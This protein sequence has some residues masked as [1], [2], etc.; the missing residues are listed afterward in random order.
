MKKQFYEK[1]LPTQG[2]Y[3]ATGIK[4]GKAVNRFAETL[5][6]LMA[7]TDEFAARGYH[8]FVA[9]NSFSGYSRKGDSAQYARSFFI[10]L[11]VGNDP[12][13]YASKDDAAV[14]L[15]E[16][17]EREGMP[18]PVVID[19]GTGL[20]AYW[21]LDQDVPTAEWRV[22][23]ERFKQYCLAHLKID[24]V[25]TADP[26]RIM[27]CPETL[28]YKTTPPSPVKFLTDNFSQC[29][30]ASFK[31]VLGDDDT[32]RNPTIKEVLSHA[33]L[34]LDEDT[35]KVS[36]ADANIETTFE[37]IA[38]KSLE[39]RGCNQIKYVLEHAATLSEPLWHSGLSI[40]RQCV[41]WGSAI[42][43]MSEDYPRYDRE[44]TI[45]KANDTY[46][47]PHG[48]E[49][50]ELRNPGGCDGCPHKGKITNPLYFG[51]NVREPDP[52]ENTV[53]VIEDTKTVLSFSQFPDDM[54]P[55]RRGPEGGIYYITEKDQPVEIW[56]YDLYPVKRMYGTPEGEFMLMRHCPP[57]DPPREFLVSMS[58]STGED[59]RKLLLSHGVFFANKHMA[60]M[61]DYIRHWAVH[62]QSKDSAEETRRQ[63]GWT[64]DGKGFVVGETEYRSDGTTKRT[65]PSAFVIQVSRPM[66]PRGSY[67]KWKE[68]ANKLNMPGLETFA[69]PM[70][71]AF[72]SPLLRF[73]N[74]S[75]VT[76]SYFG[77][78]GIGKTGALVAAASLFGDPG[79][80][81]L[82]GNKKNSGTENAL[83]QWMLGLKNIM[84][85]LD[86]AS[87]RRSEELSDLI[88]KVT[89]ARTKLRMHSSADQ[90]REIEMRSALISFMATNQSLID[91]LADK[92]YNPDG[93][94][95]RLVELTVTKPEPFR[96]R[97]SL[98]PEIFEAMR[99]N[100]GW[101]GP[102][103]IKALFV[104]GEER[105]R[106]L[107]T[108]WL[109]RFTNDFGTDTAFRFYDNLVSVG[110]AGGEIAVNAGI[111]DWDLDRIYAAMLSLFLH[112]R[113][114]GSTKLN[115][116]DYETVLGD[117]QN[118]VQ[119]GTL[120][121]NEDRLVEA[122]R[123]ATV[124]RAEIDTHMYYV[125]RREFKKYLH[126]RQINEGEFIKDMKARG[127]L[128]ITDK[129]RLTKGWP[130]H[131]GVS[132]VSVLGFKVTVNLEGLVKNG[133]ESTD[134][135]ASVAVPV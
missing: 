131:S 37:L 63:M 82:A 20:H 95:A 39:G 7:L 38:V 72:G 116:A 41:D 53:R 3:C 99:H 125:S 100:Y 117:Y 64:E 124:A 21:L 127:L 88:Y 24:P 80:L 132:P 129:M 107:I 9:L 114:D 14:A 30:Y 15:V 31:Q 40:A 55:F 103:Y 69:F 85:V 121:M 87:N 1:A 44:L 118:A 94:L 29:D 109:K 43:T 19:S 17:V 115:V 120:I 27:R 42:H 75:G 57:H 5:E 68:A 16:F 54:F 34:G 108:K 22:Y 90:L 36:K 23:A 70:L 119:L 62:M 76:V 25:V 133:N 48:C 18:E 83:T 97:P 8:T 49:V 96:R 134:G 77:N 52:K 135:G 12:R 92:K 46:D 105:I 28:N 104:L 13:K 102:D 110:F 67:D 91:K 35:L 81:C 11:D 33:V 26:A 61:T 106:E 122:P 89:E 58:E 60:L 45:K 50:F 59:I 84:M 113:D 71:C 86:E 32:G 101:A 65:A 2:V 66:K 6:Q 112:A 130:G 47:K 10:D 111:I 56:K 126:S 4:D 79:V 123:A 51:R 98:A 93:E 74:I 128:V 73:T 78:S